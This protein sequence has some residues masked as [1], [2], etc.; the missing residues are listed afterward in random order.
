MPTGGRS[1]SWSEF[2]WKERISDA[3][4]QTELRV[5]RSRSAADFDGRQN[6]HVRVYVLRGVRDE[7]VEGPLPELR[8]Q[9]RR[10]SDQAGCVACEISG[11]DETRFESRGLQGRV[12]KKAG[13]QGVV[14]QPG[15]VTLSADVL[16]EEASAE[17]AQ[18]KGIV[19]GAGAR[20]WGRT[21][22]A[23]FQIG[24]EERV[25]KD[26]KMSNRA[27]VKSENRG[28]PRRVSSR[29]RFPDSKGKL[30]NWALAFPAARARACRCR[31]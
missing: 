3:R 28:R 17:I 6:L 30:R 16:G 27:L 26:V 14:L 15:L 19:L 7:C 11:V 5:L 25:L 9:P 2:S 24:A 23:H 20:V 29:V 4:T 12:I 8:W 13:P 10:P 21:A 1:K 22:P 31:A 18:D